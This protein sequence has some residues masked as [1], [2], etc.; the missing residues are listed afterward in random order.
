MQDC[1]PVDKA[2]G[3]GVGRAA[4]QPLARHSA[5]GVARIFFGEVAQRHQRFEQ[6]RYAALVG[7]NAGRQLGRAERALVQSIEDAKLHARQH[8]AEPNRA[9]QIKQWARP[10]VQA[11]KQHTLGNIR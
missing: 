10:G 9:K 1:A 3:D 4:G 8:G 11:K 6:H 5:V 7:A 2:I